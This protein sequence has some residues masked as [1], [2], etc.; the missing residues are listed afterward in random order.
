MS[1]RRTFWAILALLAFAILGGLFFPAGP[2]PIPNQ[3]RDQTE[4]RIFTRI[5]VVCVSLILI[6]LEHFLLN[7]NL[8][9]CTADY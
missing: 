7:L 1:V 6:S 4:I 9:I 8:Q 3:L 2:F 5:I